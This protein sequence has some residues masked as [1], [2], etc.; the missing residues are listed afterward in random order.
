MLTVIRIFTIPIC[1]SLGK[2]KTAAKHANAKKSQHHFATAIAIENS[3]YSYGA[4][5][6]KKRV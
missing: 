1:I 3:V 6:K 5:C 4:C 2:L